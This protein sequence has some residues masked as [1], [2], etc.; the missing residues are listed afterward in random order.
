LIWQEN[1]QSSNKV[2]EN[3][4]FIGY[5]GKDFNGAKKLYEDLKQAGQ[6]PWLDKESI[7]RGWNWKVAIRKANRNSRYFIA[8][9][10]LNSVGKR[11]FVQKELNP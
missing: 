1:G 3:T 10:S 6:N 4:V 2:Q 11:G 9:F 5:A 8:L 7:L